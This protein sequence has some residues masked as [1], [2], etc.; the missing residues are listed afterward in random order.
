MKICVYCSSSDRIDP[1]YFDAAEA[2]GSQIARRGDTLIYG[3]AGIGLMGAVARAVKAG[4]GRVV[5]VIPEILRPEKITFSEA[6]ELVYTSDMRERKAAMEERADAFVVLPGGFGTLEELSEILTLRQL[7]ANTKPLVLL[8]V[9]GFWAPLV[10]LFEHFYDGGFARR[11]L[12]LYYVADSV[13][14]A[15][16]YLDEH[17]STPPPAKWENW[18]SKND[19]S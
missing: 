3:G 17:E 18:E 16:D 4:G 2:L 9:E 5:G 14:D 11:W 15:L 12:D 8:S 19:Q 10:A 13:S 1:L 6:D 7:R